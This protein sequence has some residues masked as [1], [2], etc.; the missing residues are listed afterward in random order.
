LFRF[1]T[2]LAIT[3]A[4]LVLPALG[5]PPMRFDETPAR[6][7]E[8]LYRRISL[9]DLGKQV[10]VA[11]K[12]RAGVVGTTIAAPPRGSGGETTTQGYDIFLPPDGMAGSAGEPSVGVNWNTGNIMFQ[13]YTET[14][15]ITIDE[16][17]NPPRATWTNVTAPN[18]RVSLDPILFTDPISG[19]T[20]MSQLVPPCSIS[21]VTPDDGETWIPSTGCG[22]PGSADHQSIG[23]GPYATP[24]LHPHKLEDR[25][26]YYCGQSV[27]FANCALSTD[28]GITYGAAAPAYADINSELDGAAAGGTC[29]GL[30]GHLKVG[31]DGTLYLPNFGCLSPEGEQV[32]G[33]AVSEDDGLTWDVRTVPG[34]LYNEFKSD[35]S[36]AIA[37]DNTLY[38]AYEPKKGAPKVAVSHNKG[39]DW[40]FAVTLGREFDLKHGVFPSAVAGDGDRAAVAFHG[41]PD[42]GK[43]KEA[44]ED[45]KYKGVWH[46]YVSSTYDGGKTWKTVKVTGKDPVQRGCIWWGNGSCTSAYRNLLDFMDATLDK[47][48]RVVVGYA[49]GCT[50][51]CVKDPK[52]NTL[53]DVGA[54]ARQAR[55]LSMF[56]KY[57]KKFSGR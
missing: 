22:V 45:A 8:P 5:A 47:F 38:F 35:P 9:A 53:T 56:S 25:A 2:V 13:A 16:T 49:D 27:I 11:P 29:M 41:T 18:S 46:L 37:K 32:Q 40:T 10:P 52:V 42:E 44:Y 21:A 14:D 4:A 6:G 31:P 20:A 48:G 28:G 55:G 34:A 7:A 3:A 26:M 12:F 24:D 15:R 43:T 19:R 30:H 54:I 36:I 39:K 51:A 17:K 50:A 23:G 57:D 33:I 1:R